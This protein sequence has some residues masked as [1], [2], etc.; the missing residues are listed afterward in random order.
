[1]NRDPIAYG[2]PHREPFIFIDSVN[3]VQP[4]VS[5]VCVKTFR[6]GEPFFRGHFPGNP[7]VPGVILTE[8]LAQAAGIAAGGSGKSYL[9]S[10]VKLMKFPAPARPNDEITLL[11]EKSG[12]VGGLLQFAVKATVRGEVVAEGAIILNEV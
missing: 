8:A 1:M 9:L 10:A 12:A 7:I 6:A 2:L 5:A 4:G 3:E 11:A